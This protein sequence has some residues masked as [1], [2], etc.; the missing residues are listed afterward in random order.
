M[1]ILTTA[2]RI[3]LTRTFRPF[4]FSNERD[5]RL[6]F[7]SAKKLGL[8]LHIPFCR[9]ICAFCPYCKTLFDQALATRYVN[10]LLGEI[11]MVGKMAPGGKTHVTSVYF[12]GGSPSLVVDEIQRIIARVQKHFIVSEGIGL[13][14]HPQEVTEETLLKLNRAGVTKISIGVQSFQEE[15]LDILGRPHVDFEPMFEALSKVPFE[16]VSMDFIF[17]L[18]R[19]TIDLLKADIELAFRRGA[20][21]IALY[22]F[23][24][25][26]FTQR[27]FP[28]MKEA[29][30]KV[31]LYQLVQY[32]ESR[33]YT[34][35]S[36][37]TFS[38]DGTSKYS[39][40]TRENFLGF[41]CSSTTLL[42]DQFKINTFDANQYIDSIENGTLA[43]ALTLTFTHRQRMVYYLF[44]AAYSMRINKRDFD[45]FFGA[46]L[47]DCYKME[48]RI[49]R[50]LGWVRKENDSY[51][52]TTKGS[53]YYHYFEHFYTLSYIDRMWNLMR[54][55]AFPEGLAIR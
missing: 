20:N 7:H 24:D 35:D 17:A 43:T 33:G 23:I 52:M 29:Q 55:T 19:Q 28:K 51:V 14:I 1:G 41:G 47:D 37:W 11:E 25:F 16:T 3:W 44:W 5:D 6:V 4:H 53:Y 27:K 45:T 30:K 39:S 50:L 32:C 18:P 48:L 46:S 13:E 8:Y 22:P 26:T 21:H 2:A 15:Y 12:G 34:R 54:G 38:K 42:K 36:I 9:S 10:A 40:M 49:A 31:L